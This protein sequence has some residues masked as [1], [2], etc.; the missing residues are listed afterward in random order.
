[1]SL[2]GNQQPSF[3]DYYASAGGGRFFR[4]LDR[5]KLRTAA[6]V[7]TR[8]G[9]APRILDLGCGAAAV[10]SALARM[11]PG[12]DVHG[13]DIDEGLLET[14]RQRGVQVHHVDFDRPLPFPDRSFD[15][16]L[17][18]DA[19]EHVRCRRDTM[20]QV[21]R[22]L[23]PAGA[24]LVFTPPYDTF[25][26]WLGERM[27]RLMTRRPTG[28]VSPF[29]KESLEWLLT[30]HFIEVTIGYLNVGLT[31]YG[32][33]TGAREASVQPDIQAIADV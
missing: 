24:F 29:T 33:G 21:K 30:E 7:I 22:L 32:I 2:H 6:D 8:M 26:W 12:A 23:K 18:I 19:I 11:F 20:Q 14:A 17:M 16:V 27:F 13:A 28:H 15:L 9:D 4:W 3:S 31:L 10:S 1:M 25:T 5:A